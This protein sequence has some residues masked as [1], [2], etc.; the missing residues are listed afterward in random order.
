MFQVLAPFANVTVTPAALPMSGAHEEVKSELILKGYESLSRY[1]EEIPHHWGVAL[2]LNKS[3]CICCTLPI[4][5]TVGNSIIVFPCGHL[6]HQVCC[7]EQ[8]CI[9][10]FSSNFSLFDDSMTSPINY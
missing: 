1:Y 4:S 7:P 3:I 5:E 6:Y 2:D 9:T 8:A 10:C